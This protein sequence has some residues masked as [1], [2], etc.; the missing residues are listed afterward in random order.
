MRAG[1]ILKKEQGSVVVILA[2]AMTA[3]LGMG[4]LVA[5]VGV[6]YVKEAHLMVAADA[7]ALAGATK[8]GQGKEAITT[9]VLEIVQKNGVLAEMVTVEVDEEQNGV[10]VKTRAPIRLFFAKLF[11]AENG[12]MEQRAR[13]AK[14]RPTAIFDVFPL[15]VEESVTLD[16]LKEVNLFSS[17]LLG[18]GKWGALTFKDENGNYMTGANIFREFLKHGYP[19]LIEIGDLVQAKGGVNMGP[20]RDGIKYR[21]DEAEKLGPSSYD[22]YPDGSPLVLI[23]PIYTITNVKDEVEVVDFAAFYV[24]KL[25][26]QGEN[27]EVWGHF[28][29]PHVNAAASVEGES[30]YGLTTTKLIQ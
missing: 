19:G 11:A 30:Q 9:A 21:Q 28:I 1:N 18:G 6:N 16:Y 24:T 14:T 8:L 2:L 13:V 27:T 4:A 23:L 26:G 15:G 5:D 3:L 20:I 12:V 7:G 25:Q 10:T 17:E 22:N 29:K